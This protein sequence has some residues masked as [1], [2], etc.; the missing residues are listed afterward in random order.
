VRAAL[1]LTLALG[2]AATPPPVPTADSAFEAVR[3][4]I[5]HIGLRDPDSGS[6]DKWLGTGFIVD[7]KCTIMTA[8]HVLAKV[9]DR[10][11][12]VG[13]FQTP[14]NRS[15]LRFLNAV[16]IDSDAKRDLAFLQLKDPRP[17]VPC[18]FSILHPL[19]LLDVSEFDRFAGEAVLMAGF[20]TL[21]KPK[22]GKPSTVV[23]R[24][25]HVGS[26][27]MKIDKNPYLLIDLSSVPG[28]SGSPIVDAASLKVIGV[29]VGPILTS[30]NADFTWATPVSV[31]DY[32]SAME[33][34]GE[35]TSGGSITIIPGNTI[36]VDAEP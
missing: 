7:N 24:R 17:N 14:N 9:E 12:L 16:V 30:R 5:I 6:L 15:V 23:I 29:N 18:V 28:F 11:L 8:K 32:E 3:D 34:A 31:S 1:A 19:K 10:S 36:G 2:C 26:T 33:R 20:P 27:E 35:L 13:A 22:Y 4:A 21:A 25:G